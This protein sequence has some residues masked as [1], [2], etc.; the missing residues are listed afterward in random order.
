MKLN[1]KIQE[2][3]IRGDSY[4]GIMQSL[5]NNCDE[6]YG[7]FNDGGKTLLHYYKNGDDHVRLYRLQKFNKKSLQYR[8]PSIVKT[9][10]GKASN[11]EMTVVRRPYWIATYIDVPVSIINSAR[12]YDR[13]FSLDLSV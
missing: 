12:Q 4:A 13:T 6:S 9:D 7:I 3:V 1:I 5:K 8:Y 11:T 10:L 2:N